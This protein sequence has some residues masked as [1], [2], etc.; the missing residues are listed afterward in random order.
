MEITLSLKKMPFES[1]LCNYTLDV[2]LANPTFVGADGNCE[3][4]QP[5]RLHPSGKKNNKQH[6][7]T[8]T[9]NNKQ[10]NKTINNNNKKFV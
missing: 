9:P 1:S 6:Q 7:T 5:R 3:C 8:R 4:G 10:K 2:L